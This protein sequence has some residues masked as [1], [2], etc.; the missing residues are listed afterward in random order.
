MSQLEL[1]EFD[2]GRSFLCRGGRRSL[3]DRRR[4]RPSTF[5]TGRR[6]WRQRCAPDNMEAG[7]GWSCVHTCTHAYTPGVVGRQHGDPCRRRPACVVEVGSGSSLAPLLAEATSPTAADLSIISTLRHSKIDHAEGMADQLV[8]GEALGGLWEAGVPVAWG[9]YNRG[10]RYIKLALP[11][12]ALRAFGSTTTRRCKC[13]RLRRRQLMQA[14]AQVRV[15]ACI[16]VYVHVYVRLR[17][18]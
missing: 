13:A 6:T 9:S 16:C 1:V 12:Y 10:E 14:K 2:A 4:P 3:A 18:S 8:F 7:L 5:P 11:T 17:R 15:C